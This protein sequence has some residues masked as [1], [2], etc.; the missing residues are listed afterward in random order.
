[1]S[2]ASPIRLASPPHFLDA[3]NCAPTII[4]EPHAILRENWPCSPDPAP[5]SETNGSVWTACSSPSAACTRT[6][7]K[8]VFAAFP[9][10]STAMAVIIPSEAGYFLHT[11][12]W[13]YFDADPASRT[14]HAEAK[15]RLASD[16]GGGT[17][18][19]RHAS[20]EKAGPLP[21]KPQTLSKHIRSL[22]G[23]RASLDGKKEHLWRAGNP[24]YLRVLYQGSLSSSPLVIQDAIQ[25]PTEEK[26]L[27][28]EDRPKY[29][30]KVAYKQEQDGSRT[31]RLIA[32]VRLRSSPQKMDR[33][34]TYT[35]FGDCVRP[36]NMGVGV[37]SVAGEVVG[38]SGTPTS[39]SR[40]KH[41]IGGG[42]SSSSGTPL[43]GDN[44]PY[45]DEK[46]VSERDCL[47]LQL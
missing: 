43:D 36:E 35:R 32:V 25:L 44:N 19:S 27:P 10:I 38:N 1:M 4:A 11:Y 9:S 29:M 28:H 3:R 23:I 47:A 37:G 24:V 33:I 2:R 31:Y 34:Q 45:D 13:S 46:V 21:G 42:G 30:K 15:H 8:P 6:S 39:S 5:E 7:W 16:L 26:I 12:S 20:F 40:R 14:N 18:L 22:L 17:P 41:L